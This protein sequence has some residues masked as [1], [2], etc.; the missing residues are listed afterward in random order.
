MGDENTQG[1]NVDQAK[2]APDQPTPAQEQTVEYQVPHYVL[3]SEYAIG[4]GIISQQEY[5]SL[6]DEYYTQARTLTGVAIPLGGLMLYL[7]FGTDQHWGWTYVYIA[8]AILAGLIFG[9]DRLH[10]FYSELQM[11]IIGHYVK[12]ALAAKEAAAT[13][14][15]AL[16]KQYFDSELKKKFAD[17]LTAIEKVVKAKPEA[18]KDKK[19]GG[20][21]EDVFPA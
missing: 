14:A 5:T 13:A 19:S 3:D 12:N 17:Q 2:P 16:T 4:M 10:K 8:S 7:R 20:G 6:R 18:S 1:S 15:K 21:T 11:L 9:L